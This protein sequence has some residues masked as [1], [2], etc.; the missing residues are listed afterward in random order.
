MFKTTYFYEDFSAK[1]LDESVVGRKGMSL[2]RLKDA[3]VPVPPFFVVSPAVF[4]ALIY[5]AFGNDIE[6][7]LKEK[8]FPDPLDVEKILLRTNF[9]PDVEEELFKE[10]AKLS[11]FNDAWVAIRSSVVYL[12]EN[13]VLF[14]GV[15]ATEVNVRGFDDVLKAIKMVYASIFRDSV[16]FYAKNHNVDLSKLKMS[17]VVQKMVQA[18]VSGVTYTK[19]LITQDES[20]MSIEAVFGLGDVISNGEITPDRYVLNK[21]D[22]TFL[23]KKVSPQEWMNIRK[24]ST[25]GQGGVERVSISSSWSHQQKLEDRFLK[26][27]A[28]ISLLIEDSFGRS[29]N[30]EWVWEGGKVWVIQNKFVY[31]P[32]RTKPKEQKFSNVILHPVLDAVKQKKQEEIKKEVEEKVCE[33]KVCEE[34]KVQKQ[35]KKMSELDE[36]IAK[37][38]SKFEEFAK[39][40]SLQESKRIEKLSEDIRKE[41]SEITKNVSK[42]LIKENLKIKNFKFLA[43]GVGVSGGN[44]IGQ[45]IHVDSK[46][47]KELVISKENILV[48][49]EIFPGVENAMFLSGGV[50]MDLGGYSSNISMLCR[51]F[52]IPAIVGVK[53]LQRIIKEGSFVKMDAN[54]GALYI[55]EES[56]KE[57]DA[58]E[59]KEEKIDYE[60]VTDTSPLKKEEKK[61]Q[62]KA[63]EKNLREDFT[64]VPDI[65]TTATDVY[66]TS[67]GITNL[68][69]YV[70]ENC[71][72]LVFLDLEELMLNE[73]RHP[74]AFVED[75]QAAEYTNLLAKKVD[76]IADMFSGNEIILSLGKF[77]SQDF[78]NLTKG[79]SFEKNEGTKGVFRYLQNPE[80]TE[81][82]L[83]IVSKARNVYRNKNIS[84]ALYSPLSR[85]NM[86]SIKKKILSS[87]LRRNS[88]FKL[89]AV[90]ENPSEVL[91]V[92]DIV[93]ANID[94]LIIDTPTLAKQMQGLSPYDEK[95][96]YNLEADSLFKTL[97]TIY[98]KVK[99]TK[100][101]IVG[102]TENNE[103]LIKKYVELGVC[104][105]VVDGEK[106]ID[107]KKIISVKETE[108]ILSRAKF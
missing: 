105:L 62:V 91:L 47:F 13:R 16:V 2:F 87:G 86:V 65:P 50:L 68:G 31:T 4:D 57:E 56:E 107:A 97:E 8:N 19:E 58:D 24:L 74:L 96:S 27:I 92:D 88:S 79:K 41:K 38:S 17:V 42:S 59:E 83:K 67:K 15:F 36:K 12:P 69:K 108:I 7:Y 48:V 64:Q 89:Y 104:G 20:K 99:N 18:E 44:K 82:A 100:A 102:I 21:K 40:K 11:G 53:N 45:V 55:Y 101:T 84:L 23:E 37:L 43:S 54:S 25:K 85:E 103:K 95:A 9:P 49:K 106:F 93:D 78:A 70:L 90:I 14:S 98:Q 73:K 75:G 32:Q 28:K 71:T 77:R 34:K 1:D 3:D 29:Q 81:I 46:N 39:K 22:L 26:E 63:E 80:L 10:Y 33:D 6:K 61:E 66:I 30:I 72:G 5:N 76:S 60:V 94:G 35:E 51:E 52:K